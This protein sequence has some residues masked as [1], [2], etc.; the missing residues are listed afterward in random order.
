MLTITNENKE[1]VARNVMFIEVIRRMTKRIE[2]GQ[3]DSAVKLGKMTFDAS[4][5]A[6]IETRDWDS[7]FDEG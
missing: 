7:R 6:G 1:A 4:R 2:N 3:S 5:D